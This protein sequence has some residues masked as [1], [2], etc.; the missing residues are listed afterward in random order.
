MRVVFF[1]SD[2]FAA[3]CLK[4][5]KTVRVVGCVTRP[6]SR[7]GRGMK[8]ALSPIKNI[9]LE[10]DMVCL[11]PFSLKEESTVQQL[12]SLQAD[13]FVVV[14]YGKILTQAVLEIPK[15]FCVNVHGSLLPKYRGAAPVNWAILHGEKETGVTIQK[16]ALALDAGDIITQQSMTIGPQETSIQLRDRMAQVGSKFLVRT[17]NDIDSGNY[18]LTPQQESQATDAPKLTKEMGKID[19]GRP[20]GQI[21][22]QIRGL[23]PWPGAFTS[24]KGKMLKILEASPDA[25]VGAGP[26]SIVDISKEG[27]IIA[28]GQGGLL[29]KSV[30]LEAGKV[31][32]AHDFLQGYR[33]TLGEGLY[34]SIT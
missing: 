11:Q 23:Q 34:A 13:I 28:C 3:T 20:A 12:K 2:D 22:N 33:L 32:S 10:H 6:D 31:M 5:L 27:F 4:E 1:G 16:M 26:G 24:Y 19:W 18:R 7:Q 8:L 21:Y 15:M 17:L 29:V 14:A 30:H 9:A 25:S